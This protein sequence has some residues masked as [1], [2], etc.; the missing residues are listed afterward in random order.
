MRIKY[1]PP[2]SGRLS[3]GLTFMECSLTLSPLK[4]DLSL[5]LQ[6]FFHRQCCKIPHRHSHAA[7]TQVP[8]KGFRVSCLPQPLNGA[9]VPKQVGID[10]LGQPCQFRCL[11][12]HLVGVLSVQVEKPVRRLQAPLVGV[13]QQLREKGFWDMD[14]PLLSAFPL[15]PQAGNSFKLG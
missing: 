2:K 7:V 4:L 6:R 11:N 1:A 8:L 9:T 3:R 10:P 12:Q 15:H 14:E 13:S 5:N